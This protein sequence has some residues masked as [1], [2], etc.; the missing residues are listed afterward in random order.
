VEF[1]TLK[2]DYRPPSARYEIFVDGVSRTMRDRKDFAIDAA[3]EL[4]LRSPNVRIVDLADGA[5]VPFD[6]S[7]SASV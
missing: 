1:V 2:P 7:S 5:E 4:C 3:R 6:K